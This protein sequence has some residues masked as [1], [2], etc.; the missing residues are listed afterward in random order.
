MR[1]NAGE[2]T[3]RFDASITFLGFRVLS[4]PISQ[5]L[6]DMAVQLLGR[7]LG[8]CVDECKHPEYQVG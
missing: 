3:Y 4:W 8:R 1:L 6:S 7:A 2:F 5:K